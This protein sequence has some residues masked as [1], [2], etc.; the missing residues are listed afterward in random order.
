MVVVIVMMMIMMTRN[1]TE[2]KGRSLVYI[3]RE[4]RVPGIAT[5]LFQSVA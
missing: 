3:Y 4:G 2:W 5:S 1:W